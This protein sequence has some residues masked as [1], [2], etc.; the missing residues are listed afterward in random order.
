[1]GA[2]PQ[3]QAEAGAPV[4]HRPERRTA[5]FHFT[6]TGLV[7]YAPLSDRAPQH[8]LLAVVIVPPESADYF[9]MAAAEV[10]FR[11]AG[12]HAG[13]YVYEVDPESDPSAGAW[14]SARAFVFMTPDA[15]RRLHTGE[16]SEAD[17]IADILGPDAV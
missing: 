11:F 3:G 6:M 12:E 5:A 10:P 17:V 8:V 9:T 14:S 16:L 2:E 7:L 4:S 15:A 1:V 13:L